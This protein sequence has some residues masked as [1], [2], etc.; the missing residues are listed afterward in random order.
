MS[1]PQ[2]HIV[3]WNLEIPFQ[4]ANQNLPEGQAMA[5]TLMYV[6]NAVIQEKNRYKNM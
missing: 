6:E 5:M 1:G 4:F 3:L 2:Q